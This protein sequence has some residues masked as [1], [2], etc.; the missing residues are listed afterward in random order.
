MISGSRK[1]QSAGASDTAGR[2]G[3]KYSFCSQ[4]KTSFLN[5][6]CDLVMAYIYTILCKKNMQRKYVKKKKSRRGD[7][8]ALSGGKVDVIIKNRESIPQS[9][10]AVKGQSDGE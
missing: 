9:F 6:F 5:S 1:A 8:Y 4:C 3:D 7:F 10:L 2:A